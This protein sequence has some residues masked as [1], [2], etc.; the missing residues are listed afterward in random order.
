MAGGKGTLRLHTHGLL[1]L[2]WVPGAILEA[3][4]AAEALAAT[5]RLSAGRRLGLIMEIVG[6]TL[7]AG[8]R[9]QLRALRFVSAVAVVGATDVDRVVAASITRGNP[10]PHGFFLAR[11]EAIEWLRG[12]PAISC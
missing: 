11:S 2:L 1:D 5:M 10:C 12:R 9:R 6:V 3:E 8:A 4:D 7:E